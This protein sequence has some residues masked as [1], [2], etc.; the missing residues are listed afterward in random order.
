ME[1]SKLLCYLPGQLLIMHLSLPLSSRSH[2][3]SWGSFAL[4][5]LFAGRKPIYSWIETQVGKHQRLSKAR[6]LCQLPDPQKNQPALLSRER[7]SQGTVQGTELGAR[8]HFHTGCHFH[9]TYLVVSWPEA[10]VKH[11]FPTLTDERSLGFD[12]LLWNGFY[13]HTTLR[14][15]RVESLI[16]P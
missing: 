8:C 1:I 5:S 14:I 3:A 4:V 16:A 12:L 11:W 9:T 7:K 6:G 10:D 15:F 13:V 2:Q